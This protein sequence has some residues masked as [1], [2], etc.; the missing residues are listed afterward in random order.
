M[1]IFAIAD[2]HLSHGENIDKP[3]DKFGDG[4]EQHAERLQAEW[5][6]AVS[7]GDLVLIPGDISWGLRL[8][9]AMADF[10]WLHSLPGTKILSKGN[11]DLWW[12]RINYLNSLFDDL[13]FLQND[14]YVPACGGIVITAS[15]GWP[16]PGS[17]EY[18][19]HDEKI[20][21]REIQR[22]RLGLDAARAKA[23]GSKILVCLHYP[24]SD[25]SGRHTGFT[26]VLE[27]YGVWKCIYGHLHGQIAFGR[28][29]KGEVR[30]VTY[31]LVSFD[32][33][34]ARPKLIYDTDN[35]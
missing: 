22:L 18:T 23:P 33:L 7:D 13:V 3:M 11:H 29:I 31:Q 17:D 9:E 25:P 1:K 6:K 12:G 8:E 30:G 15:R 19:E 4:W 35:I 16:Y 28:G 27:E 26:D 2:L 10:E 21:A 20:Y 5:K 34:G 24:P 32:Y 14:C